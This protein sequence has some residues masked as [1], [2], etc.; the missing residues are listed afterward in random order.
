MLV[1]V[2]KPLFFAVYILY[3]LMIESPGTIYNEV[4]WECILIVR[5]I[6]WWSELFYCVNYRKYW[7]RRVSY[8]VKCCDQWELWTLTKKNIVDWLSLIRQ[9]NRRLW[10]GKFSYVIHEFFSRR[11]NQDRPILLKVYCTLINISLLA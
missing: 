2:I 5:I 7:R 6:L 4:V 11:C 9:V 10:R 8:R 1:L 3:L